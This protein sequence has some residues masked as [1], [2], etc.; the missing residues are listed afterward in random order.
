MLFTS[1]T[2]QEENVSMKG[3]QS[4]P[5]PGAGGG[6][7]QGRCIHPP[8]LRI[9]PESVTKLR[10]GPHVPSPRRVHGQRCTAPLWA[11]TASG[12]SEPQVLGR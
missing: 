3:S 11:P 1:K 6:C 5:R 4:V 9:A 10:P 2:P 8:T 7:P 12:H